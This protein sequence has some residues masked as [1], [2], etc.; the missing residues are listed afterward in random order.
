MKLQSLKI[1]IGQGLYRT[2]FLT[3][4]STLRALQIIDLPVLGYLRSTKETDFYVFYVLYIK[5]STMFSLQ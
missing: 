1:F 3:V 4:I 2:L 5:D